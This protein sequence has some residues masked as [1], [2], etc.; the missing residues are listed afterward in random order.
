MK[1][2]ISIFFLI[3]LSVG[4]CEDRDRDLGRLIQ[5]AD[6][7]W[8]KGRNQSAI[9]ILKALLEK[10]SIGPIAEKVL[11][12]LGEIHY[13]S[14]KNSSKALFYF[15]E[16]Q[17]LNKRSPQSYAAQKYVAENKKRA[18]ERLQQQNNLI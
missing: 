17:R 10:Q 4:A 1:L 6:D 16:L 13:F 18:Y 11:F 9:E 5:Q 8:I 2:T 7:E 14:L 15:Q 3:L 12:R